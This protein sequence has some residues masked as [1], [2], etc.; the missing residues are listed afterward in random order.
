M[1]IKQAQFITSVGNLSQIKSFSKPEIAIAG[2]SNVGKSSF[3]NFMV[4]NK[5]LA[6]TS[7]TAGKTR[8][9]NYFEVNK[10]FMFVDLPGYGFAEKGGKDKDGWDKLIG[11]YMQASVDIAAVIIL[12]DIRHEPSV[13]D[14]HMADYCEDYQIPYF[15]VAT[16]SDKL[17]KVQINK[18]VKV[19][20]DA[21]EA[22]VKDI[23]V[24]SS[25]K[26]TGKE[27]VLSMID[28]AINNFN[29]RV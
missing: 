2:R 29:N 11:N 6:K 24:T 25:L 23:V 9:I 17:S 27:D 12:V 3:I 22:D 10:S 16:K 21:F 18:Q 1:E 14:V 5:S 4:N 19:I 13:L 26:K 20:A 28:I 15:I 8:L 7:S